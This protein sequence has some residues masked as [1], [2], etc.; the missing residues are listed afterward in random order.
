MPQVCPSGTELSQNAISETKLLSPF[1]ETKKPNSG[2]LSLLPHELPFMTSSMSGA[3]KLQGCCKVGQGTGSQGGLYDGERS[4]TPAVT[5]DERQEQDTE[6]VEDLGQQ[7]ETLQKRESPASSG[8]KVNPPVSE[9]VGELVPAV[10]TRTNRIT[11]SSKR[12]CITAA[13]LSKALESVETEHILQEASVLPTSPWGL[14]IPSRSWLM[15]ALVK[16]QQEAGPVRVWVSGSPPQTNRTEQPQQNQGDRNQERELADYLSDLDPN[17]LP[18]QLIFDI[19]KEKGYPIPGAPGWQSWL[20]EFQRTHHIAPLVPPQTLVPM[21]LPLVLVDVDDFLRKDGDLQGVEDT[22]MPP[23]IQAIEN[24]TNNNQEP[25]STADDFFSFQELLGIDLGSNNEETGLN[26]DDFVSYQDLF[27]IDSAVAQDLLMPPLLQAIDHTTNSVRESGSDDVLA[28]LDW[29]PD[30][31]TGQDPGVFDNTPRA[32]YTETS[33]NARATLQ[34]YQAEIFTW[35]RNLTAMQNRPT[36][37]DQPDHGE[38]LVGVIQELQ[39]ESLQTFA[40][41]DAAP[42]ARTQPS[43]DHELALKQ[44]QERPPS[45]EVSKDRDSMWQMVEFLHHIRREPPQFQDAQS[46]NQFLELVGTFYRVLIRTI[47]KM[48]G[49]GAKEVLIGELL[50]FRD[51][52]P[53]QSTEPNSDTHIQQGVDTDIGNLNPAQNTPRMR[54]RKRNREPDL[55]TQ[56]T[57]K[58]AH[59]RP[60]PEIDLL[61]SEMIAEKLM[62]S[63]ILEWMKGLHIMR[64]KATRVSKAEHPLTAVLLAPQ[65]QAFHQKVLISAEANFDASIHDVTEEKWQST[66]K[67]YTHMITADPEVLGQIS[68]E[69]AED[70]GHLLMNDKGKL[71]A[72]TAQY[73][74]T[75]TEVRKSAKNPNPVVKR[76]RSALL[77]A[78]IHELRE[79]A[80][81]LLDPGVA[82]KTIHIPESKLFVA[83]D[84]AIRRHRSL[85]PEQRQQEAANRTQSDI[86]TS[87]GFDADGFRIPAPRPP[88]LSP[89][90]PP[91]FDADGFRIPATRPPALSPLQPPAQ[92]LEPPESEE[93]RISE[94][95]QRR[96]ISD[97]WEGEWPFSQSLAIPVD[98]T[99]ADFAHYQQYLLLTY[100]ELKRLMLEVVIVT[101]GKQGFENMQPEVARDLEFFLTAYYDV[102]G[103]LIR[104]T[105]G[106][107]SKI[108]DVILKQLKDW[109]VANGY[110]S[111]INTKMQKLSAETG[112]PR[113]QVNH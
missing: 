22:V 21:D 15:E 82:Q 28:T 84:A 45:P 10:N 83:R 37:W 40:Q 7:T 64:S 86:G 87:G 103:R 53:D 69:T 5:W 95:E 72:W 13:D 66:R 70:L 56:R 23:P 36:W 102:Y 99:P 88:A 2:Q 80:L 57:K 42:G 1:D 75:A 31:D 19:L 112:L 96:I 39:R 3:Q 90:Q 98:F 33:G 50:Q 101:L 73:L 104:Y 25:G 100:K 94:T 32:E 113:R 41:I 59:D 89:L 105:N 93:L 16:Q 26:D 54:Q 12:Y 48:Y 92:L 91:G 35:M 61:S 111:T 79:T 58:A 67:Y 49:D 110:D 109:V 62:S 76:E 38:R 20:Q 85:P 65:L 30:P 108:P 77:R 34:S 81:S 11:L 29:L 17:H 14:P 63:S 55:S 71:T 97:G 27:G 4:T 52:F 18:D 44:G 68:K 47:E 6:A 74:T 9:S 78:F 60:Q 43:T 106:S 51:L 107:L 8:I 46:H 24:T